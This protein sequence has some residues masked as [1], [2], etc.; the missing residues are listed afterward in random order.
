[1]RGI[2]KYLEQLPAELCAG[3]RL[4]A[5]LLFDQADA[6]GLC[7]V[8]ISELAKARGGSH[9]AARGSIHRLVAAGVVS[10]VVLGTGWQATKYRVARR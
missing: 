9:G 6:T 8:S 2:C 7:C 1:M 10:V 4:T 5:S 3:D